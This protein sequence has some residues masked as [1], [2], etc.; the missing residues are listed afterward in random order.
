MTTRLSRVFAESGSRSSVLATSIAASLDDVSLPCTPNA[1]HAMAGVECAIS[2]A[3]VADVAFG[4]ASETTF[5]R[6]ESRAARFFCDVITA[7]TSGR[8]S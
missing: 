3:R 7:N 1:S 2:D 8:C 4:S 5:V 6:I